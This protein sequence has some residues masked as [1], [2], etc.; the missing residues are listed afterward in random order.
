MILIDTQILVWRTTAETPPRG[1]ATR[2]MERFEALRVNGVAVSAVS[3]WEVALKVERGHIDFDGTPEQWYTAAAGISY[4]TFL[5]L[6]AEIAL[7]SRTM[8]RDL[9]HDDP[10]D[11][12]ILA[13][14]M[15]HGL[16]LLTSD[17]RLLAFGGSHLI[18]LDAA[19]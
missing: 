16:R 4:L 7:R 3:V 5:P 19:G 14:A 10:A 9:G 15:T 6:T 18:P 13:T 1:I 2:A 12:F 17:E 11:R 8:L